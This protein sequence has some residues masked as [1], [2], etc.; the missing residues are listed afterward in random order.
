MKTRNLIE[1]EKPQF[2][3]L[4]H[5]KYVKEWEMILNGLQRVQKSGY[6][7]EYKECGCCG[8]LSTSYEMNFN[9]VECGAK[10]KDTQHNDDELPREIY[11]YK[12]HGKYVPE[13]K[14]SPVS[15]MIYKGQVEKLPK[16]SLI[17]L[18]GIL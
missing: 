17:Q 7:E 13:E 9:C 12:C 6:S 4:K 8:N 10:L 2:G 15:Y 16:P 11:C 14:D 18:I 3:N 5:I 1:G